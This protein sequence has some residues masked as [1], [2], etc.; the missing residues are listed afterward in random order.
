VNLRRRGIP[1][2]GAA[3]QVGRADHTGVGAQLRQPD[4]GVRPV[5]APG[6]RF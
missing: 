6:Q 4:L 2:K 1:V 3:R 5:E